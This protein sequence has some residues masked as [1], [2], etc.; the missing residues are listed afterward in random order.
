MSWNISKKITA[1]FLAVISLV[2]I[3]SAITYYEVGQLNDMHITTA[4]SNLEK[5]HLLELM[6]FILIT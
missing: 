4:K 3:M 2:A 5:M 1:A 6:Y